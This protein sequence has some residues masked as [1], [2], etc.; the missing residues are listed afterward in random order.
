MSAR[1]TL[2]SSTSAAPPVSRLRQ[3]SALRRPLAAAIRWQPMV[4]GTLL[5]AVLLAVKAPDVT[6]AESA[7]LW[8]R[9]V[10][11]VLASSACFVLD[12]DAAE[13]L[14]PS[15][16][17]LAR[18]RTLRLGVAVGL[19]ALPWAGSVLAVSMRPRVDV[20]V[21]GLTLELAALLAVGLAA[22]AAMD[23]W[24]GVPDP[25]VG[26][27]PLVFALALLAFRLPARWALYVPPG[28]AWDD[29]HLRWAALLGGASLVLA[30]SMRDPAAR[31]ARRA[32]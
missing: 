3:L 20:P 7:V 8:L 2:L 13:L 10:A 19:V 23:R 29:A 31:S 30:W 15:P 11:I 24:T 14:S 16:A 26:A 5:V 21:W 28:P 32:R 18:R 6:S 22:A 4:L 27:S 25:G 17:S 9:V 1:V 12:D